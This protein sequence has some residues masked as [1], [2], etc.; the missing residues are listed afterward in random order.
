MQAVSAAVR[1]ARAFGSDRRGNFAIMTGFVATVLAGAIGFGVNLGQLYNIKSN[2]RQSL[3]AAVTSTARDLTTGTIDPKDARKMVEAFL[4]ANADTDIIAGENLVL[5]KI[6]VDQVAKTVR[7]EA[8][9]DA[10]LFFP[11]FAGDGQQRVSMSSAAL[12]SDKRIEVSMMLDVTG[13]MSGQKIKDLKTAASNAVDTFLGAQDPAKPRVRLAIVPYSNSVNAGTFA[14]TSVYVETNAAD[15]KQAP[16]NDDPKLASLGAR[17]DNC[18]T[19]R[20]GAYQYS[21]AGPDASM[22][23]RDFLLTKFAKDF[24]SRACPV[25]AI[26]PLTSDADALKKT[27]SNFVAEGGTGG[28]IGIQWAWYMLSEKWGSVMDVSQRPAKLDTKKVAKYAILMT[29]GEFNLSYFDVDSASNVYDDDGKVATRDAAKKLCEEMRKGGIEVF[30]IGF[31]LENSYAIET[32]KN[33]A[34]PDTAKVR[35]YFQTSSGPELDQAFQEIARNI[36][37]LTITE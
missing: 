7:A 37:R 26:Q 25:A 22:V 6:V 11:L 29:D 14:A 27:I 35:H 2:L 32:M 28:H 3:D 24:G 9:V 31:K 5:S 16:A 33:C 18:A 4:F 19:E 34:S 1:T 13:S 10:D 15:R 12:Y 17:P 20:K 23:N 36:E 21:D 8:Y 30:T